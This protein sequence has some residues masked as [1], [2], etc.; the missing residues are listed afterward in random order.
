MTDTNLQLCILELSMSPLHDFFTEQ[1]SV[2]D[3]VL[4]G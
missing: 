3:F 4:F 2:I 1:L